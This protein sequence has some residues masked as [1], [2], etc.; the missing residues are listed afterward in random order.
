MAGTSICKA[1]RCCEMAGL[2]A[3][4]GGVNVPKDLASCAACSL[5]GGERDRAGA[6]VV[7]SLDEFCRGENE[8]SCEDVGLSPLGLGG[9]IG[10]TATGNLGCDDIGEVTCWACC[11]GEWIC[12]GHCVDWVD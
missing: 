11:E 3:A 8:F 12:W 2:G 6:E 10:F 7:I 5:G 4:E 9:T 1:E